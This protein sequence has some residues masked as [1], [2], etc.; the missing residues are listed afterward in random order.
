MTN[1][2]RLTRT[3]WLIMAGLALLA[4]TLR[5]LPGLRIIDDAYITYRYA[6]NLASG[7]GF[8]Y[9][10]GEQVLGTTTPL[11]TI[12]I[13]LFGLLTGN[14]SAIY[15]QISVTLN[16]LLDAVAVNLLYLIARN[17]FST[18]KL[19]RVPG[20]VLGGLWSLAP[21]SVTF[22]IGGM[23]TSLYITM[24]L[25]AFCA[26]LYEGPVLSATLTGFA[27]LTR[28]DALIWAGPLAIAMV[29]ENFLP[30]QPSHPSPPPSGGRVV[31]DR[32]GAEPLL[33]RLPWTEA[34]A[35]A[36]VVLP[37]VLFSWLTFGSPLTNS[38][39]AKSVAYSVSPN[40]ALSTLLGV[41]ATPFME[42]AVFGG[43]LPIMI[44][45]VIYLT[46]IVI[47]TINLVRWNWH[48]IP[49]VTFPWLYLVTFSIANPLIFRWYGT[50]PI[51]LL[52]LTIAA[53]VW[54]LSRDVLDL[55]RAPYVLGAVGI[56][57]AGFTLSGWMLHPTHGPD[58]PA[59]QMAWFELELL[60]Q[61][62]AESITVEEGQVVA[63]G[64]IGAVGW[65]SEAPLLD[66]L[67]LVSPQ[68]VDFYPLDPELIADTTAYA[69][70]PGLIQQEQPDYLIILEVYG[71]NTLMQDEW[72]NQTYEL[73]DTIDT[74]IYG[75]SG[76]LIFQR[77]P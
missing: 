30:K 55:K 70:A 58:R 62:A 21:M 64:D 7:T 44:A 56:L 4:I 41:Y 20:V 75:S 31:E 37:W 69:V 66:T 32:E 18:A 28:P 14:N 11:Y 54:A 9:N 10:I 39:S 12:L 2:H 8:V 25:G 60:Y 51:P 59:P 53:G 57:W 15:P 45:A 42:D 72:F 67:G 74:D 43:G 77:M 23:E 22:A 5:A 36:A 61:Q 48:S 68:S 73:R 26:W 76:M 1:Q 47:G 65:Y 35:F 63:A 71:R 52:M 19:Q 16:A 40:Q 38:V 46:L 3:D 6:L 50:P 24:M 33:S 17:L 49:L 27:V 34:T 13:A 29:V